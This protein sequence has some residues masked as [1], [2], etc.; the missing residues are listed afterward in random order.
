MNLQSAVEKKLHQLLIEQPL[1]IPVRVQVAEGRCHHDFFFAESKLAVEIDGNWRWHSVEENAR[2]DANLV[3]TAVLRLPW[4]MALKEMRERIANVMAEV[5]PLPIAEKIAWVQT[6]NKTLMESRKASQPTP[7]TLAPNPL[8]IDCNGDGWKLVPV[9]SEFMRQAEMRATRCKC[10]NL[11]NTFELW[12]S[13]EI[14]TR[15]PPV[16]ETLPLQIKIPA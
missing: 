9:F 13:N 6:Y 4:D 12:D 14:W 3:G 1:P 5:K 7:P 2:R 8:C 10:E 15:K 16:Q 11:R